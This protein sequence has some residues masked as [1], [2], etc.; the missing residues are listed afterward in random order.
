MHK[1]REFKEISYSTKEML[2]DAIDTYLESE[3]CHLEVVRNIM[4]ENEKSK[5][6]FGDE[7]FEIICSFIKENLPNVH[8]CVYCGRWFDDEDDNFKEGQFIE[9]EESCIWCKYGI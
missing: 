7:S 8:Y 3:E 1:P 9:D 4:S 6:S 5:W 2:L